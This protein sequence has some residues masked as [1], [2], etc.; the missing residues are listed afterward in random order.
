MPAFKIAIA[1]LVL[2]LWLPATSHCLME[3]SGIIQFSDCCGESSGSCSGNSCAIGCG[4]IEAAGVKNPSP[5][6]NPAHPSLVILQLAPIEAP[7]ISMLPTLDCSGHPSP[8]LSLAEFL[9]ARTV[10]VRA[11]SFIV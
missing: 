11:P 3:R 1:A 9:A 6:E 4:V 8:N 5:N 2:T 10:R 7:A